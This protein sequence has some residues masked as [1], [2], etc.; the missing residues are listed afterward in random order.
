MGP[1]TSAWV[2]FAAL[3]AGLVHLALVVGAPWPVAAALVV[4][5]A[6]E[7]VWGVA[8]LRA[9][10]PPLPRAAL[11]V[12]LAPIA[13]WMATLAVSAVVP[14]ADAVAALRPLP[15]AVTTLLGL[16]AAVS[17]GARLRRERDGAAAASR[18]SSPPQPEHAGRYLV[19]MLAGA[20][21]VGA[22]VTPALAGTEAGLY[23]QP[24]GEHPGLD[25]DLFPAHHGR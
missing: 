1:V 3:G 14:I 22:L 12:A 24:H 4:L 18:E 6:A 13:A 7:L 9:G 19:G 16:I 8:A 15:L 20:L 11:A 17:L 2:A 21:V 23:A 25:L 10:R 5:G